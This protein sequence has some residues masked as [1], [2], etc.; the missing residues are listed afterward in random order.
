MQ[1]AAQPA[2][3]RQH[4]AVPQVTSRRHLARL[5]SGASK[6]P[7]AVIRCQNAETLW[8]LLSRTWL[9]PAPRR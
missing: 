3:N 7:R 8:T 9:G 2:R 1:H 5:G 4:H 6:G